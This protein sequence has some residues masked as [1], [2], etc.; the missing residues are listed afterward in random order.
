MRLPCNAT[1]NPQP[2][3]TWSKRPSIITLSS[4]GGVLTVTNVSKA[5]SGVYQCK[6][7]NGIG[8]DA[9]VTSTIVVNCK[10]TSL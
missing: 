8:N 6:A 1:G 3:V 9:I 7:S 2:T 4:P 10:L 5:D